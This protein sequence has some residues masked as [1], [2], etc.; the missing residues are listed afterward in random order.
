MISIISGTP[1]LQLTA[2]TSPGNTSTTY[3]HLQT[4]YS[5]I[6]LNIPKPSLHFAHISAS[7]SL[8][9]ITPNVHHRICHQRSYAQG[10]PN[11]SNQVSTASIIIVSN[12]V[13]HTQVWWPQTQ[14]S[15]MTILL[16]KPMNRTHPGFSEYNINLSGHNIET[17]APWFHTSS[18]DM[19]NYLLA[20]TDGSNQFSTACIYP[21]SYNIKTKEVHTSLVN[22]ASKIADNTIFAQT[23]ESIPVKEM[24]GLLLCAS[25]MIK[26]VETS[27][28]ATYPCLDTILK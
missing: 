28:N 27:M 1:R 21:V 11:E 20:I 26:V 25:N 7:I 4:H 6:V 5:P 15:L 2:Q 10:S 17:S 22:T 23:T 8:L 14:G 3:I 16:Y 9:L 18:V 13:A 12:L 19:R 24:H